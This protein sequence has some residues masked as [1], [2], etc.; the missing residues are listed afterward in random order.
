M[1]VC[2]STCSTTSTS[3]YC[4]EIRQPSESYNHSLASKLFHK[5]SLTAQTGNTDSLY[6]SLRRSFYTAQCKF[7]CICTIFSCAG[8]VKLFL[9]CGADLLQSFENPNLW[10]DEEVCVTVDYDYIG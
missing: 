10:T 2:V 8:E 1:C 3:R 5:V 4:P 7:V 9:L 6:I